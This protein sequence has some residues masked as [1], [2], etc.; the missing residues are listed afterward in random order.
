LGARAED[1]GHRRRADLIVTEAGGFVGP[2]RDGQDPLISGN[3]IA[4]NAEIFERFA[5]V[6]RA[7]EV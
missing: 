4:A 3:V 7:R 2:I 1:L 5:K 6:I